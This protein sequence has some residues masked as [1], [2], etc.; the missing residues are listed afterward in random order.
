MRCTINYSAHLVLQIFVFFSINL[1]KHKKGFLKITLGIDLFRDGWV[2]APPILAA[3]TILTPSTSRVVPSQIIVSIIKFIERNDS[4]NWSTLVQRYYVWGSD[5]GSRTCTRCWHRNLIWDGKSLRTGNYQGKSKYSNK[6][7]NRIANK[8]KMTSSFQGDGPYSAE[9]AKHK[10]RR[11][12]GLHRKE[13]L[14]SK[15]S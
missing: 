7:A 14:E 11:H 4:I 8:I 6:S 13:R 10:A 1:D 3:S 15:L 5:Y 2:I 9:A 12:V